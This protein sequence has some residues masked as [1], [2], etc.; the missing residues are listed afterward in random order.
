MKK[1]LKRFLAAT[2]AMSIML[3]SSTANIFAAGKPKGDEYELNGL[4]PSN[5]KNKPIITISQETL[6]NGERKDNPIRDVTV[7]IKGAEY[8]YANVGFSVRFDERLT[9][10]SKAGQIALAGPAWEYGQSIFVPDTEHGFRAILTSSGNTGQD[11]VMF[12]F[13]V[14]LP[15]E[16]NIGDGKYP[17]E[18]YYNSGTDLF[19]NAE[20]DAD[21]QL[22]E[23]WLFTQ[24][25]E[26]G[27]IYAPIWTDPTTT[28]ATTTTVTTTTTSVDKPALILGDANNDGKIDSIDASEILRLFAKIST[29]GTPTENEKK[30]C[31]INNDGMIDSVDASAVLA[32]YAKISS[33]DS[34]ESFTDYLKEKGIRK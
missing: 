3:V 14:Q 25:I 19:S 6:S 13:R 12:K 34:E 4:D 17:I 30:V 27:Y 10:V 28:K 20:M 23:A 26:Q 18:V 15:D 32:Y 31:D 16:A 5:A 1:F 22:M 8:A 33:S 11:G 9:L 29:G 21:G 2:A 24:G 7:S